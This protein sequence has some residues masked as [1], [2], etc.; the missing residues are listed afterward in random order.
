[1]LSRKDA[2]RMLLTGDLADAQEAKRIGLVNE[3]VP[4]GS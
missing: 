2:M 3:V 4:A 1:M